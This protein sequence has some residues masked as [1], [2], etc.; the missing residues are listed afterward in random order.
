MT[1]A[2][3]SVGGTTELSDPVVRHGQEAWSRL[4][5]R[6]RHTWEDW[7]L[8]GEALRVGRHRA[9]LE[10]GTNK[11]SGSRYNDVF[12]EWLKATGFDAIDKG[13]RSRLFDCLDHRDKIERWREALPLS[14]RL[15]LNHPKTVLINWQKTTVADK[16][17][18]EPAQLSPSAKLKQEIVRLE[19]ENLQLR[20]AGDD[21]FSSKDSAADIARLLADRLLQRLTPAK[22]RQIVEELP[23]IIAERAELT[24]DSMTAVP[25]K[26]GRRRTIEDFKRDLAK[27]RPEATP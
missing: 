16:A 27:R 4:A 20:R 21:L 24:R 5:T 7:V 6:E 15:E 11:P 25:K 9:M 3:T 1:D 13:T 14:R 12:G 17:A 19:D 23:R 10:A 22:V 8:V 26:R 18:T 2:S